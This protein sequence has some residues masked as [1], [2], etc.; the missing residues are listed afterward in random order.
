MIKGI[1][2][3]IGC[4]VNMTSRIVRQVRES[5][6][7]YVDPN[8]YVF[9]GIRCAD[10][11]ITVYDALAK[12][13]L[14]IGWS[15]KLLHKKDQT[16]VDKIGGDYHAWLYHVKTNTGVDCSCYGVMYPNFINF[17]YDNDYETTFMFLGRH[18]DSDEWT[19]KNID[20]STLLS[21]LGRN[22]T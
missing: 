5:I 12:R 14:H 3:T 16:H 1:G 11:A 20:R 15:F 7:K 9:S 22:G 13:N 2:I 17:I 10:A 21:Y 4:N 6:E 18:D 19:I 8:D